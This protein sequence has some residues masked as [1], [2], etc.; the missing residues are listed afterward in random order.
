MNIIGV[1]PKPSLKPRPISIINFINQY[2][3]WKPFAI[4][5][6]YEQNVE[7]LRVRVY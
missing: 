5:F 4:D 6:G 7:T 3:S 2:L 1:S